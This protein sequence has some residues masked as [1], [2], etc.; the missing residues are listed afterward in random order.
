MKKLFLISF[1]CLYAGLSFAEDVKEVVMTIDNKP[2]YK[3]EFEYYYKKNNAGSNYEKISISDYAELFVN[4]KL[5]VAEAYNLKMDTAKSFHDE[6]LGYRDYLIKP[7]LTD[8]E[9]KEQF[10]KEEYSHLL[11]D[12]NVSH[13]LFTLESDASPKDTLEAYKKAV[14]AKKR[15]LNGEKFEKV[16]KEVSEDPSARENSGKLGYITGMMVVYPFEKAA[17]ATP[18]GEITGP[19]RTRFGY[20][21]IK[22]NEKRKSPGEVLVAHIMKRVPT[23]ATDSTKKE[24]KKGVFDMY[25]ELV[26]G[27]NFEEMAKANSD[28]HGTAQKGGELPWVGTGKTNPEFEEAAFALKKKGDI[29]APLATSYGWHI[30]KLLD[31]R[32]IPKIEEMTPQIESVIKSDERSYIIAT[33]FVNKL[34]KEYNFKEFRENQKAIIALLEKNKATDST[35][36]AKG[37]ELKLPI[38]SFADKTVLQSDL[39]N[40]ITKNSE[41]TNKNTANFVAQKAERLCNNAI[42]DYENSNLENKYKD[43]GLLMKEYKDGILLFNI[44]NQKIWE[45]ASN[46][47]EGLKKY[48]EK[49]KLNYKWDSPRFKGKII[50]CSSKKI[51]KAAKKIIKSYPADSVNYYLKKNLNVDGQTNIKIETGLYAKGSNKVVDHLVFKAGKLPENKNFP[52]VF[53]SGEIQKEYP[54]SYLDIKGIV[55]SD[56]QNY[57]DQEW[58][59]LLRAKFPVTINKEV[60]ETIK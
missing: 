26:N 15:I 29:S 27:A 50:Y 16:A 1:L 14:A 42:F 47:T 4:F 8:N 32:D 48:F 7:Y 59:K 5:K 25:K 40:Y 39:V 45:K 31:K 12:V 35:F 55:T 53:T 54:K 46:D 60:L 9:K 18:V 20:H 33:S 2:I 21:I 41:S 58:V 30:I 10:V 51:E 37:S 38:C 24:I 23:D 36:L 49:N 19:I 57:L 11:E 52:N 56:Y 28:D 6:L 17:Y 43:F 13:I 34:K 44:S 3:D 22:V